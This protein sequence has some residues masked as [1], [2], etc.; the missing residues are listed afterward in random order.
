MTLERVKSA[1]HS[2]MYLAGIHNHSQ[3][4]SNILVYN[5]SSL[6]SLI[7]FRTWLKKYSEENMLTTILVGLVLL[8]F[9]VAFCFYGFRAFMIF[10]PVMGFIAG[11]YIGAQAIQ[12]AMDQGF[13]ATT[14]SVVFGLLGGVIGAFASYVFFIIGIVLVAGILGFA[15][16]AAIMNLLNLEPGCIAPLL[17]LG[18]AGAAVWA[19]MRYK[20][21][22]YVLILI[23][24]VLGANAI[25]LSVLL[26]LGRVSVEDIVS[27]MGTV[28]PVLSNSTLYIILFVVL[29]GAG[30]YVQ[31]LASRDFD[32]DNI[33]IFERWSAANR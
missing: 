8:A 31:F 32:F 11:F 7:N 21:I 14:L 23:T 29:V 22:R 17:G 9:G 2:R 18:S 24:A 19:T 1:R 26:F 12:I 6:F 20:L 16:A 4:Y 30:I 28:A 33:K 10:L 3:A 13:L 5:K 15:V 27:P 25:L